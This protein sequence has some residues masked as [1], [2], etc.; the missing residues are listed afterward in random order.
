MKFKHIVNQYYLKFVS[1]LLILTLLNQCGLYRKTDA[2]K[3][4]VNA[5]QRVQK[6]LEEGKRIKFADLTKGSGKF[7]FATANEM[8]RATIDVLDFIPLTSADY[9]G[10]VIITDWYNENNSNDSLKIM[11]RFLSNE[12]RADGLK[13]TVYNKKC[14]TENVTNC[15]TNI[16]NNSTISEEL[17]LAVLRKAAMYKNQN[18]EKEVEEYKKDNAGKPDV[19]KRTKF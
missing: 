10:G 12:I 19:E 14:D 6:N 7:E 3:V 13:I 4:P 5:K 9:G 15:K 16:D 11:V 17:K 2:R 18:I 1:L 8:W